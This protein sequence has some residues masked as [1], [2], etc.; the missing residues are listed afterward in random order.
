MY[1]RTVAVLGITN[2]LSAMGITVVVPFLGDVQGIFGV[3][4]AYGIWIVTLFMLSY[5]VGMT[6]V[7]RLSD[8]V[9]RRPVYIASMGTF[10]LGLLVSGVS[11]GFGGVLAG[12]FLQGLG[13]SGTLPLAQAIAYEGFGARRGRML[14]LISAAFGLGVVAAINLGGGIYTA[15]GWRAVF[16]VTSVLAALGFAVSTLLP[17]TSTARRRPR[18]DPGGTIAFGTAIAE[19]M[20]LFKGLATGPLLSW[21][22]LPYLILLLA[23]GGAF[24]LLETRAREPMIDLSLFRNRGFTGVILAS[25]LGGVGMFIFQTF[26]PSYAQLLL[27]YSVAQ[28]AYSIDVMAAFM[29]AAAGLTGIACDR[30]GP[31]RVL[32]FSLATTALAFY[33]ITAIPAPTWAYYLG[34]A[35]AGVGLGSLMPPS[36]MAAI[37]EAGPGREG[38][39]SGLVSLSRTLGGIIGPTVGGLILARTNFSSLF[40]LTNILNS[41]RNIYRFGLWTVLAGCGVALFLLAVRKK[42]VDGR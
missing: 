42:E 5:C 12:R 17:E 15:L 35:V 38:I 31:E 36:S 7:G 2:F 3:S 4:P 19:F 9:G 37:R 26:L 13:A 1:R 11:P 40:A 8:A 41:Y 27:G 23:A 39:S 25:L 21:E 24:L 28:A 6:F 30:F 14:G 32:L 16:L 33:L 34:S 20:L 22:A 29:I 18:Y 10:A